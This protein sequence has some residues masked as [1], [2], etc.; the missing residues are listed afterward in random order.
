MTKTKNQVLELRLREGQTKE[1]ALTE[2]NS[3]SA[4]L[5]TA[6]KESFHISFGQDF[7]FQ[8]NMQV[9]EKTIQEI[10]SGDLSKIEEMYISQAVALEAMFASLA[11]R[12]KAQDK[13]LQYET[14]MRLALKAQNQCRATLQA[15]VQLKQPSNTTFVK[16]ANI[17]QGHQQVNN[18][19]EKNITP[20][21]ELL[22]SGDAKLDSGRKAAPERVNTALEALD[23]VDRC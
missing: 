16:Q 7:N 6:T 13:L 2:F 21:N 17:A 19:A 14:H 12:A 4:F 1:Q 8:S 11:R 9:L 10:Q 22:R 3:K 20:Q 18:L 15:L 23:E 5:S